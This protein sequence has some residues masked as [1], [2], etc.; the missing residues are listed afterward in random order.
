M[1]ATYWNSCTLICELLRHSKKRSLKKI[2]KQLTTWSKLA[3]NQSF[4]DLYSTVLKES[5]FLDHLLRLP[6]AEEKIAKLHALYD[7]AKALQRSNHNFRLSDFV[8]FLNTVSTHHL[9]IKH[10]GGGL[11]NG[12]GVELMTA[13]KSKGLEF[14]YVY[15]IN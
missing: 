10:R 5:G 13:H 4:L 6:E 12:G 8:H 1:I 15:I 11:A 9:S 2:Y 14:D 3:A 7:E